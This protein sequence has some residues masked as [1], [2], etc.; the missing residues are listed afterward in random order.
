[1]II[2]DR[3]VFCVFCVFDNSSFL[4]FLF[5]VFCVYRRTWLFETAW[6]H[7]LLSD[8]SYIIFVNESTCVFACVNFILMASTDRCTALPYVLHIYTMQYAL[9]Y[10]VQYT[11]QY[12]LSNLLLSIIALC[13][14]NSLIESDNKHLSAQ[15]SRHLPSLRNNTSVCV[16]L[17]IL[18]FYLFW[19]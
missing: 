13:K 9:K 14:R 17:I 7:K 6:V 2:L 1:M 11:V 8:S 15:Q 4:L 10:A 16:N 19:P 3:C 5:P 12:V 18:S